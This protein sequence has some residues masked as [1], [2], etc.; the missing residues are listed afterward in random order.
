LISP[1]LAASA[2]P[3]AFCWAFDVA[4]MAWLH[5]S[6]VICH[7]V[8]RRHRFRTGRPSSYRIGIVSL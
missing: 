6:P 3:A 8:E 5:C 4:G 1:R 2:A 7:N